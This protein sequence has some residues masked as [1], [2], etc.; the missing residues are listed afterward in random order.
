MGDDALVVVEG[1][2]LATMET[3]P[4]AVLAEAKKAAA[5]RWR[6]AG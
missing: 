5:A 6:N 3:A 1:Q 2:P 4:T